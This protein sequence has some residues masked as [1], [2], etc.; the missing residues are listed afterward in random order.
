MPE[1]WYSS[2][3][4]TTIDQAGRLVVPKTLRDA[5]GLVA[6]E[7]DISLD[8]AGLH[9]EP[10][11]TARLVERDGLMVVEATGVTIDDDTVQGLRDAD[12]R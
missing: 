1:H 8:G 2:G 4:R 3:M 12:Q 10:V 6:G 7:V 9:V 5:V 11:A